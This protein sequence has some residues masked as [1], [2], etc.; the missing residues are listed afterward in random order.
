MSALAQSQ[1]EHTLA[2][3]EEWFTL[4]EKTGEKYEY[5]CG[6]L[7]DMAETSY[8]HNALTARATA[9]IHA[10]LRGKPCRVL[11]SNQRLRL[12]EGSYS[13]S[14]VSVVCGKPEFLGQG[15]ILLNPRLVIEVLSASTSGYD[16]GAKKD[17]YLQ[18]PSLQE[19]V[20]IAQDRV[21]VAHYV[22]QTENLWQYRVYQHSEEHIELPSLECSIS[23][24]DL[25]EGISFEADE[26]AA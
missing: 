19:Y 3:L 15:A 20:L 6:E 7:V 16:Q 18:L 2:S 21:W 23:M 1:G 17:A 13:Y 25:Y 12:N 8:E 22:R 14:D 11:S 9:L 10:E 24:D 5:R 26:P 4:E